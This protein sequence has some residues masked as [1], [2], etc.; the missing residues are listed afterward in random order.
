MAPARIQD[1][2]RFRRGTICEGAV[3][4]LKNPDP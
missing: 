2:L 3:R 4:A 1:A